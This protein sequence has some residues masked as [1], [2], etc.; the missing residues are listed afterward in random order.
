VTALTILDGT[1]LTWPESATG[2]G[3]P[4]GAAALSGWVVRADE[5]ELAEVR[6][7]FGLH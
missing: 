6:D 2:G 3:G 5:A 4:V 1:D 7:L